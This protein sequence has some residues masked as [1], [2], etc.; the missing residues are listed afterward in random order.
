[1]EP[2]RRKVDLP[3]IPAKRYLTIGE[4]S[5]LCGVKPHVL[6]YWEQGITQLTPVERRGA[7]SGRGKRRAGR[8]LG[9]QARTART[10]RQPAAAAVAAGRTRGTT[11][12][13]CRT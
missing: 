9:A 11:R 10:A 2:S 7:R 13:S 5:D 4:V 1:M 8:Q 12:E 3:P 6:S